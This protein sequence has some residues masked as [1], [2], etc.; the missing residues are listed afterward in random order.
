MGVAYNQR[1]VKEINK[2]L[3]EQFNMKESEI[4][5]ITK[6]QFEFVRNEIASG[7]RGEKSTFKSILLKYFGT[8]AFDERRF[9]KINNIMEK[10]E[11]R[12]RALQSEE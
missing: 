12:R 9:I 1:E 3:A 5:K 11:E 8:F 2:K 7:I 10:N 4:D 6:S